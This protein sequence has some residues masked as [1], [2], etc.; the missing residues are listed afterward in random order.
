MKRLSDEEELLFFSSRRRHTIFDCDWS[1]DVC[2]SDLSLMRD[3]ALLYQTAIVDLTELKRA[4]EALHQSEERV[5][6]IVE[7]ATVGMARADRDGRLLFV[8]EAFCQMLGYKKSE[9]IGKPI[10]AFTHK[11][12]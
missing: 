4:E 1:S 3:G 5:R 6:A 12:E 2:S 7:Q 10:S 8:N 9:L 11:D